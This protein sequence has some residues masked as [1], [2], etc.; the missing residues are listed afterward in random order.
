MVIAVAI[1]EPEA[2]LRLIDSAGVVALERVATA[3]EEDRGGEPD[4][5]GSL[6][7]ENLHFRRG[8]RND[9]T[10]LQQPGRRR[11]GREQG[12]GEDVARTRKAGVPGVD[13]DRRDRN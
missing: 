9:A 8:A 10:H 11:A 4:G 2:E 7:R 13:P 1:A 12:D 6:P 3:V 5:D